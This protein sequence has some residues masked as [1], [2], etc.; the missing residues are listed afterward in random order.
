MKKKNIATDNVLAGYLRD[1]NK[2][3]LLTLEEEVELA[4]RAAEGD[5]AA[6]DKLIQANLR[7]V[8][9]VAKKY[10]NQ[11]LPLMDLISEGNI[12]LMNAADRFDVTKGYK[13]ISYAVWWIR[14]SIL[15]AICEKSRM[16]RLPLNRVGELIQIEKTRKEIR[17]TA[18]EEEELKEVADILALDHD[19]VKMIVNI[20][21]EPVSLDAP[22]FDDAANGKMGDF[23]ED[24]QYEQPEAYMLDVSL[25]ESIDKVINT[26][27]KR[28][29]E[30]LR[31]RF[32]LNGY[33]QLSLKD[34]GKI[35]NLTKERI[36]QIEK[37]SLEQLK[38]TSYKYKLD[39]YVA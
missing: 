35:F 28:E 6:K 22:L 11:G 1:I 21:R 34:V 15:K 17:S 20:G 5:K 27:P 2:I 29:A 3:P 16:I 31:Y 24:A 19:T 12:G 38:A 18:S 7:F 25:K 32:G 14:Q 10:Q 4:T 37:K 36:R 26:L 8:V 33:K 30:I 9:N 23:I 39:A 13:F